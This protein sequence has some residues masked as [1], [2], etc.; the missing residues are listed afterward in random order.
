M[1]YS[2]IKSDGGMDP[3]NKTEGLEVVG[4]YHVTLFRNDPVMRNTE[5]Q[6]VTDVPPGS[7]DLCT[8]KSAQAAVEAAKLRQ[9]PCLRF[10]DANAFNHEIRGLKAER[11]RNLDSIRVGN[12]IIS[13]KNARIT[14]L[15]AALALAMEALD[16]IKVHGDIV[17]VMTPDKDISI[18]DALAAIDSVGVSKT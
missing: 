16:A 10:C 15:E 12:K 4:S 7:Y 17:L 11:E 3:R 18:V 9:A 13:D 14:Q 6:E 1:T 8:V 2:D 5:F